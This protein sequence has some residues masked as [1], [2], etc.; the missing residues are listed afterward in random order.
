M[1]GLLGVILAGGKSQRFGGADALPKPLV[2]FLG[3]P[4]VLHAAAQLVRGGAGRI[5]VLSGANH[6][7][8]RH[9]LGLSGDAGLLRVN[10]Q[11]IPFEIRFSGD[12]C[13]TGGRL[14]SLDTSELSGGALI[15]YTD[16][17]AGANLADLHVE[18]RRNAAALTIL[19]AAPRLPWGRVTVDGDRVGAFD[20][21][22]VMADLH[23]NAGIFAADARILDHIYDPSE[24]FEREPMQ[25]LI[26]TQ[27]VTVSG[28]AQDWVAIDSPKDLPDIENHAKC[29]HLSAD[30]AMAEAD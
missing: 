14:L 6:A 3:T 23:I 1:T 29:F 22:P 24:M 13:G 9:G 12:N 26:E 16:V 10:G 18:R 19:T 20:E 2:P 27:S 21:K 17:F 28:P 7:T 15:S 25:R 4:M 30:I 11:H 5:C 8:V